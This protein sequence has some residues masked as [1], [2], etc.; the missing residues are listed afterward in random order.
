MAIADMPPVTHLFTCIWDSFPCRLLAASGC[1]PV[2]RFIHDYPINAANSVF[3]AH[4]TPQIAGF[5]RLVGAGT[6]IPIKRRSAG[7]LMKQTTER[8]AARAPS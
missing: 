3:P 6:L 8:G 5:T 7:E 2:H 4:E 1:E